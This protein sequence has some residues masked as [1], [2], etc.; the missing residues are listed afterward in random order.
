[1]TNR[2][3]ILKAPFSAHVDTV[4]NSALIVGKGPNSSGAAVEFQYDDKQDFLAWLLATF[5]DRAHKSPQDM[6]IAADTVSVGIHQTTPPGTYAASFNFKSGEMD[7]S[8]AVRL[9]KANPDRIAA[10]QAHLNAFMQELS[11]P[12]PVV[13]Q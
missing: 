6:A 3:L 1:M 10:A 9:P 11:N 2:R 5:A 8:F 13:K 12:D 7:I 4:D